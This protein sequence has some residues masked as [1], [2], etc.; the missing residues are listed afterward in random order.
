MVNK[1]TIS[2]IGTFY[3]ESMMIFDPDNRYITYCWS[4]MYNVLHRLVQ[5]IWTVFNLYY[6]LYKL[7][8]PL[9]TQIV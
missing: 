6:K 3:R 2:E 8:G 9:W 1:A 7:A 4:L 5:T